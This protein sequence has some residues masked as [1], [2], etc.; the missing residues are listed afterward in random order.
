M[1]LR[2]T[3]QIQQLLAPCSGGLAELLGQ[4]A[5][6]LLYMA[7]CLGEKTVYLIIDDTRKPKRGNYMAAGGYIYD[8]LLGRTVPGHLY[9]TTIIRTG[10]VAIPLGIRLY[11]KKEHYGELGLEFQRMT[12]HACELVR[13]FEAPRGMKV[14]V[15][16]DSFYLCPRAM[17]TCQEKGFHWIST[18]NDNRT[19]LIGGRRSKLR[20]YKRGAF[21]RGK[22]SSVKLRKPN[23]GLVK[24]SY[25]DLGWV[26]T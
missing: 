15:L 4:K 10:L 6:E 5:G 12:E 8:N 17:R 22:K 23:G 7:R 19:L 13:L 25:M 21:R 14:P 3:Y 24:Y 20:T 2:A 16:F 1:T 9:V 26:Q 18:L 11:V